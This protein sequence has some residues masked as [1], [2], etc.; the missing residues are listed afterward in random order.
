MN[1]FC[2]LFD[3]CLDGDKFGVYIDENFD[4][5]FDEG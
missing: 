4:F 3:V 5:I 1:I 2:Y